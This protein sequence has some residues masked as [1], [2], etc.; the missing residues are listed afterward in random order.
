MRIK[1]LW[2]FVLIIT[3]GITGCTPESEPDRESP[4]IVTVFAVNG[5]PE[6]VAGGTLNLS[7]RNPVVLNPILNTDP[8][9]DRVLGLVFEHLFVMDGMRPVPNL[10]QHIEHGHNYVILLM[11]DHVW[12]DG[13]PITANDVGY[14]INTIRN[15]PDSLYHHVI[16]PIASHTIINSRQIQINFNTNMGG[17]AEYA[18]LF[19]VI[20]MHFYQ[21][22]GRSLQTLAAGP[23]MINSMMLPREIILA[24]N[25]MSFRPSNLNMVRVII[26]PDIYTDFNALNQGII[27]AKVGNIQSLSLYGLASVNFNLN[28]LP[29]NR[30][31]FVGFNFDNIALRD[32]RVRRALAYIFLGS[33]TIYTAYAGQINRTSSA[34]HPLAR[35]YPLNLNY[36]ETDLDLALLLFNEAGYEELDDGVLGSI[37]AGVPIPFSLRLVVNKENTERMHMANAFLQNAQAL[38][39]DI[40]FMALSFDEYMEAIAGGNFDLALAGINLPPFRELRPFL[41]SGGQG[42]FMNYASSELDSLL[43][44]AAASL[45][46]WSFAQNWLYVHHYINENLPI[47][48][49]GFRNDVLFTR[50]NLGGDIRPGL[51]NLYQSVDNWVILR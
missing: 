42:N 51:S 1:Y 4:P 40:N 39:L 32:V 36:Y 30:L 48:P 3:I 12:A 44:T 26:T 19:P 17:R 22:G 11:S 37:A 25:P 43:H 34:A 15:N 29:T 38:G 50:L 6:P 13:A 10:V 27:Y 9:V 41:S 5:E 18:L 47:L 31:E 45:T 7:M 20:P 8:T 49:I 14:T 33:Q 2:I 16:A 21:V 23:F 46:D 28:P 35:Y 24:Q